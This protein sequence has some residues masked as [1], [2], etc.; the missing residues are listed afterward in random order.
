MKVRTAVVFWR[1]FP[2]YFAGN[3]VGISQMIQKQVRKEGEA[4]LVFVT[5][6]VEEQSFQ[7]ALTVL[8]SM[9]MVHKISAVIQV[10]DA[11]MH[12]NKKYTGRK[13]KNP[14]ICGKCRLQFGK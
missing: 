5:D 12:K 11:R 4:E 1:E 9:S 6:E 2:R 3:Q 8:R 10:Y 14:Y 13:R 7:D